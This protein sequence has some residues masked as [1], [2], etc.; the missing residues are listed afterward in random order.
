[1]QRPV[2]W[3]CLLLLGALAACVESASV[4]CPPDLICPARSR[5]LADR[6]ISDEQLE[7]CA[8]TADLAPCLVSGLAGN[9]VEGICEIASC[10]NGRIEF[11]EVC[12]DGNRLDL[13]GCRN[14]CRSNESCGNGIT[15]FSA[16]EQCD[17]GDGSF[18]VPGCTTANS[19]AGG[20]CKPDCR[21]ACGD[22]VVAAGEACDGA[23]RPFETCLL[24]Q[25]D[26]GSLGCQ[27]CGFDFGGCRH[28]GWHE[29]VEGFDVRAIWGA[30]ADDVF[31]V[32]ARGDAG[33]VLHFDGLAWTFAVL[34][35]PLVDID[36]S[37][38]SVEPALFGVTSLSAI[39]GTGPQDVFAVGDRA[40]FHLDALG[41]APVRLPAAAAST[42]WSAVAVQPG[43]VMMLA[44]SVEFAQLDR[45]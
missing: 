21:L 15:D 1:M 39:A 43:R 4:S 42:A 37:G 32:G 2:G 44:M 41:W 29:V 20:L 31:A 36:G 7:A 11:G 27:Q 16:D 3:L 22:D 35:V 33:V 14:D 13:D 6:C 26:L 38:W 45:D 5:C 24:W 34:G 18:A 23:A 19:D 10:G 25:F 12:D 30:A 8:D 40:L 28:I 17:C 9:C